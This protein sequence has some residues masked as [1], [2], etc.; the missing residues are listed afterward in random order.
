MKVFQASEWEERGGQLQ[1]MKAGGVVSDILFA[2]EMAIWLEEKDH[3]RL[4]NWLLARLG[5]RTS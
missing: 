1:L 2:G 4:K 3:A 5:G